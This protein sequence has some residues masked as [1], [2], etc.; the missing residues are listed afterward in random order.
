MTDRMWVDQVR[1]LLARAKRQHSALFDDLDA[2]KLSIDGALAAA[3]T[4]RRAAKS[5]P[6][7]APA[8]YP[9]RRRQ[10]LAGIALT[11]KHYGLVEE[12]QAFVYAA[13]ATVLQ[14]LDL[15]QLEALLGWLQRQVDRMEVACDSPYAAPAR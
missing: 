1:E 7:A 8:P 14:E 10:L 4:A 5:A 9:I 11:N 15:E 13:G 6:P 3:S 2:L 12:T